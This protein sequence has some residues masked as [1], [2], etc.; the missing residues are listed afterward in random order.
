M[1]LCFHVVIQETSE[2]QL[3][4]LSE[5]L[6]PRPDQ[7]LSSP[8]ASGSSSGQEYTGSHH[9]S[10]CRRGGNSCDKGTNSKCA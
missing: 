10:V 3:L 7:F 6:L 5:G 8:V 1:S 2:H 4:W 9:W